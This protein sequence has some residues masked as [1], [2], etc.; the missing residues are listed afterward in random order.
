ME[1]DCAVDRARRHVDA[2]DHDGVRTGGARAAPLPPSE[3]HDAAGT[4]ATDRPSD[5]VL[6]FRQHD[7]RDRHGAGA[8]LR[9]VPGDAGDG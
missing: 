3:R 7:H 6:S 1:A 8:G 4:R 5:A 9:V 2:A